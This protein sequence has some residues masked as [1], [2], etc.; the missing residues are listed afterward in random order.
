MPHHTPSHCYLLG[1]SNYYYSYI[2]SSYY[3]GFAPLLWWNK[4]RLSIYEILLQPE[5]GSETRVLAEA[6]CSNQKLLEYGTLFAGCRGAARSLPPVARRPSSKVHVAVL[7]VLCRR[8]IR[9]CCELIE[10]RV[11]KLTGRIVAAEEEERRRVEVWQVGEPSAVARARRF[12][13]GDNMSPSSIASVGEG[14]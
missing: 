2:F 8:F 1:N 11:A 13:V 7:V 10:P 3:V 9:S 14:P 6:L 12:A 5:V 4:G